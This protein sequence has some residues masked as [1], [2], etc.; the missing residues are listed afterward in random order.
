MKLNLPIEFDEK[1]ILIA[2]A[3]GGFDVFAGMPIAYELMDRN[4]NVILAN[5]NIEKRGFDCRESVPDDYPE[6]N[7]GKLSKLPIYTIAKE[8]V[9]TATNA[10]NKII[11]KHD[12]EVIILCDGGIDS[13]MTGAEE[14][15]GT[16]LEDF[17]SLS[18]VN[19][20]G[21]RRKILA[22][23]GFGTEKEEDVCHYHGLRNIQSLVKNEAFFGSCAL[24]KQMPCF[25][26]YK[27]NCIMSWENNRSSHIHT[28]IIP[29]VLG[30][31]DNYEMYKDVDAR[32]HKTKKVNSFINSFMSLYWFFD[33][34][35]VVLNNKLISALDNTN[36]FTDVMMI[37]RQIISNL[38]VE[39]R[40]P[41]EL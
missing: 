20:V 31:F 10:Y 8:G 36:T 23:I 18:A 38:I 28:K 5:M 19:K 12:I 33:L 41:V 30:E 6:Y 2:G 32:I 15:C 34:E 17:I 3:G 9:K 16:I 4:K 35:K 29:A 25:E 11:Q 14:G 39:P 13:L 7:L 24:T 40:K 26:K 37:Y 21:V 27:N 1:N 22:C